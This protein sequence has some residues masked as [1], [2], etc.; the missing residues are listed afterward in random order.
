MK[1]LPIFV[2]LGALHACVEAE[3]SDLGEGEMQRAEIIEVH[4]CRPGTLGER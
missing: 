1:A 3:D 4:G 2:A